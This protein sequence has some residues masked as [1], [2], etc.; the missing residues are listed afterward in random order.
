M[1]LS[2][3]V[4]ETGE[5][6][7]GSYVAHDGVVAVMVDPQRDVDRSTGCSPSGICGARLRALPPE[8]SAGR[9]RPVVTDGVPVRR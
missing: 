7:D 9:W 1:S 3:A 5:L 6:G 4:I 2:V 8:R